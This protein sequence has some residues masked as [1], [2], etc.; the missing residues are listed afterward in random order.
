[1]TEVGADR[2]LKTSNW[3]NHHKTMYHAT[4]PAYRSL[5]RTSIMNA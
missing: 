4:I 1:M 2:L 3:L 5:P